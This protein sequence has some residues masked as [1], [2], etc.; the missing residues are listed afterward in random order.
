M[1]NTGKIALIIPQ[2]SSFLDNELI[3][4]AYE[5]A[6]QFGYDIVV[7]TGVFNAKPDHFSNG[8]SDGQNNIYTLIQQA[9]FDGVIFAAG[10]FENDETRNKIFDILKEKEINYVS[11]EY[12]DGT[13]NSLF[14]HQRKLMYRLTKHL[15][16]HHNCHKLYCITGFAD[17]PV[18][19]ERLLGFQDAVKELALNFDEH[20]I[21]YG[22]FWR[23]IPYQIGCDIASGLIDKPD[24][25]I[26]ASDEMAIYLCKGLMDNGIR[27]PEDVAV[28]GYDGSYH[29]FINIP[30]I[31]TVSGHD[32]QLGIKAVQKLF[33][34]INAD[35][36]EVPMSS[37]FI[38]F[39]TSCGCTSTMQNHPDSDRM[40]SYLLHKTNIYE[41]RR[42][43]IANDMISRLSLCNDL[44]SLISKINEVTYLLPKW[45]RISICLC[46]DWCFD[47]S[48][49]QHFRRSGYSDEMLLAL[50][51]NRFED[52]DPDNFLFPTSQLF[53]FLGLNHKP[54]IYIIS[55]MHN[56][57]QI[58][59]FI[60]TS[61]KNAYDFLI[62]E[63]YVNWC[64]AVSNGLQIL[65]MRLRKEFIKQQFETLSDIE[66]FTGLYNRRG[67]MEHIPDILTHCNSTNK[68]CI[69]T[70]IS[71][72]ERESEISILTTIANAL[73]IKQNN[74]FLI[75][76]PDHNVIVLSYISDTDDENQLT[77]LFL[78]NMSKHI[79]K[80]IWLCNSNRLE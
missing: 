44:Q 70:A 28:T 79:R 30:Q 74:A 53:S 54:L 59:G 1:H 58:F 46:S 63:Y 71:Y 23:E 57:N 38:R 76:R 64:D 2:I 41:E 9:D 69:V 36:P 5:A 14:S 31:T 67:L 72:Q 56:K 60:C 78:E 34:K 68:K 3:G 27:V 26:C 43:Y 25:I 39:G 45:E 35:I 33:Q 24:G 15:I 42:N 62:D 20:C 4:G 11:I 16:E 65:Q 50:S 49:P 51:Q 29:A 40:Y 77:D 7:L 12:D 75:A 13:P 10:R 17:D 22:K 52:N 21:F 32:Y 61:Y 48:N 80:V 19:N 73:R 66:P 6:S 47:L 18:S 37:Q 55:S 8:Y